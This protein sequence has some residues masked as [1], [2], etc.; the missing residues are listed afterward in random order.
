MLSV[1]TLILEEIL[2]LKNLIFIMLSECDAVFVLK[3]NPI[4]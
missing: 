1:I 4:F 2:L 3:I